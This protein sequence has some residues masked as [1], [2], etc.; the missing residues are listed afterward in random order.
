M[1]AATVL[2][3]LP[4]ETERSRSLRDPFTSHTPAPPGDKSQRSFPITMSINS[5]LISLRDA[6]LEQIV[7]AM[8][9][10][11]EADDLNYTEEEVL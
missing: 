6:T 9:A 4:S 5:S 2:G 10:K 3:L 11:I 7:Q 1:S 8:S